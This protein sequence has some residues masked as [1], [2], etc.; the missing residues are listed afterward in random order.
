MAAMPSTALGLTRAERKAADAKAVEGM[1]AGKAAFA[2]IRFAGR[3]GELLGTK[4]L[5]KGSV[6][7][8]FE[9]RSSKAT[10][11]TESGPTRDPQKRRRGS[12]GFSAVVRDGRTLLVMAK[13]LRAAP[14]H[15]VVT[16]FGPRHRRL[17]TL[18]RRVPF[19]D[20]EAELESAVEQTDRGVGAAQDRLTE[21]ELDAAEARTRI[22]NAKTRKARRRQRAK[23]R[24]F[25]ATQE[26]AAARLDLL[27][28]WLQT[29][30]AALRGP[31]TREC[32]DGVDNGD[33]EDSIA[34]FGFDRDPGCVM[35]LDNDEADAPMPL[36]CPNPG[37]SQTA[38]ATLNIAGG[39]TLERFII[40]LPPRAS[41]EPRLAIAD[42]VVSGTSGGP[43]PLETGVTQLCNYEFD[44]VYG[45]AVLT[46]GA[47]PGFY[48][49][50]VSVTV[51]NNGGYPG[52]EQLAML[53]AAGTTR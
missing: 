16:T 28:R 49:L 14:T 50:R 51:E 4:G 8:R 33:P 19:L 17:D 23:L 1:A 34:D 41:D 48:R 15:V 20:L 10:T 39:N 31:A 3:I 37:Q 35:K 43:Y 22:K 29:L 30:E 42:Q 24:R 11:I 5:R 47:P 13:G 27:E 44:F 7:V 26:R 18:R 45:Y 12:R 2:E 36:T 52:G 53:L 32:N 21:A 6:R 46:N 38:S 40:S 25:E 9:R